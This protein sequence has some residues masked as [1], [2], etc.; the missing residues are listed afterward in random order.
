MKFKAKEN[1]GVDG[2][3]GKEK[4]GKCKREDLE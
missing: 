1:R 3:E 2:G 4:S